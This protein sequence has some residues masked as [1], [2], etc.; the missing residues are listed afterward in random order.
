[1]IRNACKITLLLLLCS[2]VASALQFSHSQHR[3]FEELE[4]C[5]ICHK[6]DALTISP[7]TGV[8]TNCH[9]VDEVNKTELGKVETH[10]SFWY[11]EHKNYNPLEGSGKEEFLCSKC[12]QEAFCLDCHKG[13]FQDETEG[14]NIHR[15]DYLVTHPI[16][17]KGDSRSCSACHEKR[18]CG[19]CHDRFRRTDLRL[20]SHRKGW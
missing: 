20:Y 15:S 9:S 10:G 4:Q 19:K 17:A 11:T 5:Q 16:K 2:S 7:E 3:Q 14:A 8:C 1:M 6:R 12:H 13:G 18:F